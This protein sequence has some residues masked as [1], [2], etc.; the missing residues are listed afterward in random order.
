MRDFGRHVQLGTARFP[1]SSSTSAAYHSTRTSLRRAYDMFSLA[2]VQLKFSA[3]REAA[4]GLIVPATLSF[5]A[6][7][8]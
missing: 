5:V 4:G 6:E 8:E 2:G 7:Q 1:T 3:V